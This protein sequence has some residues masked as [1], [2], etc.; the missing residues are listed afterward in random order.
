MSKWLYIEDYVCRPF[1]K[2]NQ[3]CFYYDEYN[4]KTCQF[5][6]TCLS[7]KCQNAEF[8]AVGESCEQNSDCADSDSKIR[9]INNVCVNPNNACSN[10]RF[11]K[12]DDFCSNYECAP[13]VQKGQNCTLKS[14]AMCVQPYVCQPAYP[15]NNIIGTCQPLTNLMCNYRNGICEK[16]VEPE[17]PNGNCIQDPSVC[18]IDQGCDCNG[19]CFNYMSP[20]QNKEI[21]DPYN[22][23]MIKNK[24]TTYGNHISQSSCMSKHCRS[25][26]C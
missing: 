17:I 9:C 12:Y 4:S 21:M 1:A 25:E 14:Y 19:K 5:G 26:A 10:N 20:I 23:C 6:L 16:Y 15:N 22:E 24:C 7:G 3:D 2:L 11:C 18:S 8:A 13:R